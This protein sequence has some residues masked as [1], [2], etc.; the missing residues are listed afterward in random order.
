[1]EVIEILRVEGTERGFDRRAEAGYAL[2]NA[3]AKKRNPNP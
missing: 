1:M 3:S 2:T